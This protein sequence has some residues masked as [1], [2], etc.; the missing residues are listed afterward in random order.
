MRLRVFDRAGDVGAHRFQRPR[1][2]RGHA[3][4]ADD[5]EAELRT[6]RADH[7]ALR[8][9]VG[10]GGD[11][12]IGRGRELVAPLIGEGDV[13]GAESGLAGGVDEGGAAAHALREGL[14]RGAIGQDDR[15]QRAG[16]ARAVSGG[17]VAIDRR[18]LRLGRGRRLRR[19]LRG[20][21]QRIFDH[22]AL[23]NGEGGPVELVEL[24]ELRLG[25]LDPGEHRPRSAPRRRCR[26]AARAAARH[27]RGRCPRACGRRARPGRAAGAASANARCRRAAA[28]RSRP[29]GRARRGS[30][31]GRSWPVKL[32]KAGML[33][34]SRSTIARE[35]ASPRAAP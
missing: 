7:R 10:R 4:D 29:A 5:V 21:D 27:I 11:F 20:A 17:A 9:A 6:D 28:P 32:R 19:H 14:R 15:L 12:G 31:S 25:R 23:G 13:A 2:G 33:T 34:I 1:R 26:G 18:D 35:T 24:A 30:C 3:V 16:F 22:P 8:G